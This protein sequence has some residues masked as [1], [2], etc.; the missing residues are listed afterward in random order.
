MGM[1]SHCSSLT[2]ITVPKNITKIHSFAFSGCTSLENITIP[3]SVTIIEPSAFVS[4]PNL[5]QIIY[6]GTE[7]EWNRIID[8]SGDYEDL[9]GL[10]VVFQAQETEEILL[11]DVDQNGRVETKD[12]VLLSR[13]LAKWQI[14]EIFSKKATD[15][16]NDGDITAAEAV[17][18]ARYLAKW[19][20]L[21]YPVGTRKTAE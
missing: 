7:A 9:K 21:P 16:N 1:F 10:P 17:V 3:K 12:K 8:L 4:C 2:T 11:G 15:F 19:Q 18:I 14:D 6:L 5:S 13:Y 20:N